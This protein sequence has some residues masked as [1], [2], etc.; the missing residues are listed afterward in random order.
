MVTPGRRLEKRHVIAQRP[1]EVVVLSDDAVGRNR[2]NER[3]A[4]DA[5]MGRR[6]DADERLDVRM[7]VVIHQ[8]KIFVF[9]VKN[10]LNIRVD[11]HG[12]Q[13]TTFSL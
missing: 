3:D 7:G 8:L 6:S 11:F 2:R 12:R 5:K 13:R 4:H 1:N 9:E 10:I